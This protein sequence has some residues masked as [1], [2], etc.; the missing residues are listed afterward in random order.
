MERTIWNKYYIPIEDKQDDNR[1]NVIEH[2]F[3]KGKKRKNWEN[4]NDIWQGRK[5]HS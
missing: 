3:K 5:R 4:A 1:E 2:K